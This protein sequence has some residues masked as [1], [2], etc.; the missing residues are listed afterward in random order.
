MPPSTFVR[1]GLECLRQVLMKRALRKMIDS[2]DAFHLLGHKGCYVLVFAGLGDGAGI[3]TS[4][5]LSASGQIFSLHT[6]GEHFS[7][8]EKRMT[9]DKNP[10]SV[11]PEPSDR[12]TVR[13]VVENWQAEPLGRAIPQGFLD[14]CRIDSDLADQPIQYG[15]GFFMSLFSDVMAKHEQA[16]RLRL[17]GWIPHPVLPIDDLVGPTKDPQTLRAAVE[18]YVEFYREDIYANLLARFEAYKIELYAC[19]LGEQAV[20]AHRA[21]LFLLVVP[22]IF[23]E[24]ERCAR[25]VLGLGA[26]SKEKSKE[27]KKAP[28]EVLVERMEELPLSKMD[29]FLAIEAIELLDKMYKRGVKDMPHRHGALHGLMKYESSR[30][31]LNALFMLDFVLTACQAI[32]GSPASVSV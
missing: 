12:L 22:A 26:G 17:A 5:H 14:L 2:L 10:S 27:K 23:P 4:S 31:G 24:I 21:N 29:A 25:T 30:D 16:K 1:A 18:E 15:M 6:Q 20:A 11:R 32:I 19:R 3:V 7:W 13:E 28:V 8:I 9:T